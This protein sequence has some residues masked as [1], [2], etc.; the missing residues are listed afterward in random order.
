MISIALIETLEERVL[1]SAASVREVASRPDAVM[2]AAA[3]QM[4]ASAAPQNS[5]GGV[6]VY[7][8]AGQTFTGTVGSFV[9]K[10]PLVSGLE[11]DAAIQWGDGGNSVGQVVP[12]ADGGY[13]VVGSHL[14]QRPGTYAIQ[15]EV[16][17][18]PMCNGMGPCP[19]FII[20]VARIDSTAV[21][22]AL[23]GDADFDGKVD[24]ADLVIVARHYGQQ[25]AAWADGDFNADGSVGFDDLVLLAGNYGS[26][27]LT[28]N[29]QPSR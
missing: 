11:T 5:Q 19:Q 21:V 14:Y 24:F 18:R 13:D 6:T 10:S 20:L 3:A 25:N 29:D 17:Q 27:V 28:T 23:P 22:Q 12:T 9:P 8:I 1:L 2:R 7:P 16:T 15:V 4:I 26:T